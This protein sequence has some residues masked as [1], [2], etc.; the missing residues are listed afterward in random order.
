MFQIKA[1]YSI[2]DPAEW[3]Y[4]LGYYSTTV[5]GESLLRS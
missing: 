1:I 2:L 4:A 3:H 5:K